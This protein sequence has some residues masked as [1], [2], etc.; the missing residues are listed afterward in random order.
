MERS[1]AARRAD[2]LDHLTKQAIVDRSC[3][4]RLPAAHIDGVRSSSLAAPGIVSMTVALGTDVSF[5]PA[6]DYGP[7]V[8][9]A[10]RQ[11]FVNFS[12]LSP[13]S[14]RLWSR[15]KGL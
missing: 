10:S 15:V 1:C 12:G 6:P 5:D 3:I 13:R 2:R 9:N 14:S 7:N 4:A 11:L 8:A